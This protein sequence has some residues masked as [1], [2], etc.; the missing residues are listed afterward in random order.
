MRFVAADPSP[1]FR[2]GPPSGSYYH[3]DKRNLLPTRFAVWGLGGGLGR[4]KRAA[5][6]SMPTA[7]ARSGHFQ[8]RA[9]KAKETALAGV[10]R[11]HVGALTRNRVWDLSPTIRK[12]G[13]HS[14]GRVAPTGYALAHTPNKSSTTTK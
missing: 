14:K 12:A 8:V 3:I 4:A 1:Y 7:G 11:G 6:T 5:V 13:F 10:E 2:E 9:V